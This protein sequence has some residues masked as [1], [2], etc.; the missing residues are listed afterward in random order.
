MVCVLH[1]GWYRLQSGL[2]FS[3]KLIEVKLVFPFQSTPQV[4]AG[5]SYL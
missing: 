4:R 2:K 1:V 3:D 5:T